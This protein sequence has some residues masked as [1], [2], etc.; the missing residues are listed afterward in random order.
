MSANDARCCGTGRV[1]P[2]HG[3]ARHVLLSRLRKPDATRKRDRHSHCV[4]GYGQRN[5]SRHQRRN[6]L[7]RCGRLAANLDF[8]LQG[9]ASKLVVIGG[10]VSSLALILRWRNRD[11]LQQRQG[12][13]SSYRYFYAV[14]HRHG[15]VLRRFV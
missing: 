6:R 1:I 8:A 14:E 11:Y 4:L 2:A 10:R 9:R 12:R 5:D 13:V 7:L 15:Q 3:P